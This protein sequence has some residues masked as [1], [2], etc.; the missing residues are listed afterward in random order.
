MIAHALR[1][2]AQVPCVRLKENVSVF[3]ILWC[4]REYKKQNWQWIFSRFLQWNTV[5][6]G[7]LVVNIFLQSQLFFSGKSVKPVFHSGKRH[8]F[9]KIEKTAH[10]NP[11]FFV[12]E[13]HIP[14]DAM[15]CENFGR[16]HRRKFKKITKKAIKKVKNTFTM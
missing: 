2:K 7:R 12:F 9:A 10:A 13:I 15:C 4:Q 1:T 6:F 3:D 16:Y 11:T 14:Q 8:K 5:K